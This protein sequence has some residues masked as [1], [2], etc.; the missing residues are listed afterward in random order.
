[1]TS[2]VGQ[3]KTFTDQFSL[4]GG[5]VWVDFN[6][7]KRLSVGIDV[8]YHHMFENK[9]RATYHPAAGQ[10][11]TALTYNSVVDIPIMATVK[12]FIIARGFVRPYVGVGIGATY[13]RQEIVFSDMVMSNKS[14]SFGMAP[15]LGIQFSLGE[16]VPIGLHVFAKY[17]VA[18]DQFSY[19]QQ[20]LSPY[21]YVNVGVGLLFN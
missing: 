5:S 20:K 15:T 17:G 9:E 18:F 1:M 10:A 13:L 7:I 12:C 14:W 3:Y 2:P 21:Q 6:I 4:R 16:H 8:G 11:F 19:N